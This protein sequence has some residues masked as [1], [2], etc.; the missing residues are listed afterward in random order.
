MERTALLRVTVIPGPAKQVSGKENTYHVTA[1]M[2]AEGNPRTETKGMV[3]FLGRRTSQGKIC[4]PNSL[5]R[6]SW[7]PEGSTNQG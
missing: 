2:S 3:G 6:L 4:L 5:Q 1:E 7:R